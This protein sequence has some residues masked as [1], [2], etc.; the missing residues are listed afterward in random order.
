MGKKG[1]SLPTPAPSGNVVKSFCALVVTAKR[2]YGPMH[3]FHYLS[4][5]S[6]VFALMPHRGLYPWTPLGTFF[7]NPQFAHPWKKNPAGAHWFN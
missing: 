7:P 6:G 2:S 5:A 4:L 1:N 3:Y